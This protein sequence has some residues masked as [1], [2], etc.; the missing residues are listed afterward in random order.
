MIDV[1]ELESDHAH[2]IAKKGL[3]QVICLTI[4]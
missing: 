2:I 4:Y 3:Q 1:G